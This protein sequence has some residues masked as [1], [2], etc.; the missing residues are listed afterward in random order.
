ME[1]GDGVNISSASSTAIKVTQ[2]VAEVR[3]MEVQSREITGNCCI[4][5]SYTSKKYNMQLAE[6]ISIA[7]SRH[8]DPQPDPLFPYGIPCLC[9]TSLVQQNEALPQCY[10]IGCTAEQSTLHG[11]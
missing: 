6:D 4:T 9:T 8:H 3:Q 2:T 10:G 7:N 11:F 1:L 5:K